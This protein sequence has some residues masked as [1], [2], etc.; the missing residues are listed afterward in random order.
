MEAAYL[1]RCKRRRTAIEHTGKYAASRAANQPRRH[2]P[3]QNIFQNAAVETRKI[4]VVAL[5]GDLYETGGEYAEQN[6][7]LPA[8]HDAA[9]QFL[10][11]ENHA[12]QR[13]VE[14]CCQTA[15]RARRHQIVFLHTLKRQT[16]FFAPRAPRAHYCRADLHGRAFASDGRAEQHTQKGQRNLQQRLPEAYQPRFLCAVGQRQ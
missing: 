7:P 8:Q 5:N 11:G 6:L 14:R 2:D 13:R 10:N 15:R 3:H 4:R 12:R 16:V 9:P 1:A